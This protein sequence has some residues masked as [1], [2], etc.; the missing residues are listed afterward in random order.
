MRKLCCV[1]LL[2]LFAVS[3]KDSG[4]GSQS[5]STIT[6]FVPASVVRGQ[7]NVR[8]AILGTNFSGVVIV[9]L[10]PGIIIQKTELKSS[11]EISVKF[12]V[13]A[14]AEVGPRT[15]SVLTQGGSAVSNTALSVADNLLPVPSFSVTP[16]SGIINSVLTFDASASTDP[17][18]TVASYE[19]DFGDGGSAQGKIVTHQ[20]VSP[21]NFHATL[22]VKDNFGS[23]ATASRDILIEDKYPPVAHFNFTPHTGTVSTL[24]R[25]DGS[26]STDDGRIVKYQ[27]DFGDGHRNQGKVVTHRFGSRQTF[28]VRL[29]VTDNDQL[30]GVVEKE[31][32]VQGRPPVARFSVSPASGTTS[33]NFRFDASASSDPDGNIRH[34]HWTI[35]DGATL[36]GVVVNHQFASNGT[37][38][39]KLEVIDSDGMSDTTQQNV[40]VSQGGGGGGGDSGTCKI[41]DFHTNSFKVLSV[42]GYVITAN[43][44]F[45]T[46]PSCGEL[47]RPGGVGIREFVGDVVRISGYQITFDPKGL[48]ESTRPQPGETLVLVWKPC[49][50]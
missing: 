45:R 12:S 29:T 3:C 37:Y 47:R 41:N 34:Y 25:F 33:T 36:S 21:G 49:G 7:L 48:P 43:R 32:V 50:H 2:L 17:D 10:G 5:D 9:N 27:W 18:G 40:V 42:S 8:G 44:A 26:A 28:N 14:N 4:T 11:T 15:I 23:P 6:R 38:Q 16:P 46:C 39:V 31:L 30:E 22:T 20:F 1:F 24:F 19:W 35:S 13:D